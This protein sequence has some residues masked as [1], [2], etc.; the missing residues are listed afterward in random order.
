MNSKGFTIIELL[1]TLFI[2]GLIIASASV[3]VNH[4]I[5]FYHYREEKTFNDAV[6]SAACVLVDLSK[7]ENKIITV[8]NQSLLDCRANNVC[9]VSTDYLVTE[10][11]LDSSLIDPKTKKSLEEVSYNVKITWTD[12]LKECVLKDE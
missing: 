3:G 6:S 9:V 4:L 8:D 12:G 1:V 7:Y 11:L 5:D 10:G 2:M